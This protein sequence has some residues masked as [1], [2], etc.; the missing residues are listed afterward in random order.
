MLT[1]IWL[2]EIIS[3]TDGFNSKY[4][5]NFQ[6]GTLWLHESELKEDYLP[7]VI[8]FIYFFL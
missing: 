8:I 5:V 3:V 2:G 7:Y 6:Q 1:D 4:K